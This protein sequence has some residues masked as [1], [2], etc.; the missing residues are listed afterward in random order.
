MRRGRQ[1]GKY[2]VA[3]ADK[4]CPPDAKAMTGSGVSNLPLLEL[5]SIGSASRFQH[6]KMVL[7]WEARFGTHDIYRSCLCYTEE[8]RW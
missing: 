6:P 4:R 5:L 1:R 2:S 3:P 8:R 7:F